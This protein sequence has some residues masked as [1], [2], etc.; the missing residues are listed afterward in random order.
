V[1]WGG[2]RGRG[3]RERKGE[4]GDRESDSA[5]RLRYHEIFSLLVYHRH[6]QTQTDKH[7]HTQKHIYTHIPEL[8]TQ[9]TTKKIHRELQICHKNTHQ[10]SQHKK[11]QKRVEG[12][13]RY[14]PKPRVR[15]Q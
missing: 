2:G 5:I 15:Y 1:G 14:A 13:C 6:R 3:A 10:V 4:K 8:K 7:R 12:N 9:D 11:T